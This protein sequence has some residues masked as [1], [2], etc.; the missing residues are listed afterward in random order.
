MPTRRQ[1]PGFQT[2]TLLAGVIMLLII[3][4]S[5]GYILTLPGPGPDAERD[6]QLLELDG[7]RDLW[8]R[9]RPEAFEYVVDRGCDCA[10]DF[11]APYRVIVGATGT[12]YRFDADYGASADAPLPPEPADIDRLFD[13]LEAAI[14]AGHAVQVFYDSDYGFPAI[15]RI[16]EDGDRAGQEFTFDVRGFRTIR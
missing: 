5:A 16:V 15:A 6:P 9:R 12:T 2:A 14:V 7:Q 8:A 1:K 10:A 13:R 11:T 4:V 3:F